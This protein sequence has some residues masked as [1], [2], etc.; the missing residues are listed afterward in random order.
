VRDLDQAGFRQIEC[1]AYDVDAPYTPEAWRGRIR[2]SAGVGASLS[3]D[4]VAAFDRDLEQLLAERYP[5]AVLPVAHRV[6]AVL[7]T[8]PGP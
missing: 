6:F 3:P 1:F 4:A 5:G 7:G 2:A 8:R